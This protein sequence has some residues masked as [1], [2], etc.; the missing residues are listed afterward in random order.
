MGSLAKSLNAF[1]DW[2]QTL[3]LLGVPVESHALPVQGQCP[4]CD[5]HQLLIFSDYAVGGQWHSCSHCGSHGDMVELASRKWDLSL[6]STTKKLKLSGVH[7]PDERSTDDYIREY[8]IKHVNRRLSVNNFFH[9]FRG[10]VQTPELL[11]HIQRFKW[12]IEG[13]TDW[14]E[15]GIN[16]LFAGAYFV[17]LSKV[18]FPNTCVR[19]RDGSFNNPSKNRLFV[20]G[21]W[22][23]VIVMPFYDVPG[24]V[25]GL[26]AIGRQGNPD[27]DF[28]HRCII[29]DSKEAGVAAHPDVLTRT[30]PTVFAFDDFV[31]GTRL[32][33]RHLAMHP[34]PLPLVITHSDTRLKTRRA[35]EMFGRRTVVICAKK[36]DAVAVFHAIKSNGNIVEVGKLDYAQPKKSLELLEKRSK[37]WTRV[38]DDIAENEPVSVLEEIFL[39]LPEEEIGLI[40]NHCSDVVKAK[41]KMS[42]KLKPIATEVTHGA[43]KVREIDGTWCKVSKQHSYRLS[44]G[45][46]LISEGILRIN[47]VIRAPETEETYYSG[48]IEYKG[49]SIPFCENRRIVEP[50]VLTWMHNKVLEAGK[51]FMRYSRNW[52]SKGVELAAL[53]HVPT[54][55]Q[56]SDLVGWD[57]VSQEFRLTNHT[58]KNGQVHSKLDT[59]LAKNAPQVCPTDVSE[60]TPEEL[61]RVLEPSKENITFWAAWC[62][63]VSNVIAPAVGQETKGIGVIGKGACTATEA[64]AKALGCRC[65]V[66]NETISLAKVSE[67]LWPEAVIGKSSR[68][69]SKRYFVNKQV[70]NES[71]V[72]SPDQ[73]TSCLMTDGWYIIADSSPYKIYDNEH[74]KSRLIVDYLKYITSGSFIN[75][76]RGG[77]LIESVFKSVKEFIE[78]YH[79]SSYIIDQSKELI[80]Y[81]ELDEVVTLFGDL[82]S[83][84]YRN[85]KFQMSESVGCNTF[86]CLTDKGIFLSKAKVVEWFDKFFLKDVPVQYLTERLDTAGVLVEEV[87]HGQH[88]GWIIND[89][90]WDI[91]VFGDQETG[92]DLSKI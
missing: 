47:K 78:S 1:V 15:R 50:T 37:H 91:Y 89:I 3:S 33:T 82:L 81:F 25:C 86:A 79:E 92:R 58:V 14:R 12:T 63:Y 52:N 29:K 4:M 68:R 28:L 32:Q 41:A 13:S 27:K 46:T 66:L 62:A 48:S 71:V 8:V 72:M 20:G 69:C 83:H 10:R 7:I 49:H 26:K 42:I 2:H 73:G 54:F 90:W 74:I 60:I 24:R 88:L 43:T 36:V 30:G 5:R 18:L 55:A 84:W 61:H 40:L 45:S 22:G 51:G 57:N 67:H 16:K 65:R 34:N 6:I 59:V 80:Q 44:E 19:A 87:N 23:E 21:R 85:G 56:S 31:V 77:E 38:I 11:P 76:Y 75:V 35:W 64:A 9:K 70:Y 39:N 53:F 17:E